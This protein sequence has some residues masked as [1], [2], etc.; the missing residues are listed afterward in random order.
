MGE[1]YVVYNVS[2]KRNGTIYAILM[3]SGS[4]SPTSRQ[5]KNGISSTNFF[6]D[7]NFFRKQVVVYGEDGL[8]GLYQTFSF[9]FDYLHDNTEYDFYVTAE[10][11]L[12][13]NPDILGDSDMVHDSFET[14][15]ETVFVAWEY[16]MED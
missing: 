4:P 10:N 8:P 14:L 2:I 16:G 13:G 7:T 12:P 6:L 11:S 1:S 3:N 9:R 5:L 15:R